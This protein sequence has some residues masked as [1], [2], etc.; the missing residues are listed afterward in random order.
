LPAAD[1]ALCLACSN[2]PLPT[3]WIA[4]W[5][6]YSGSLERVLHAFKFERHDFLD[7]ELGALLGELFTQRDD[8]DFDCVVPVP[9]HRRK[10]RARGYNQ[11][12]LL[13]RQLAASAS[14]ESLPRLLR[15]T[16]DNETQSLLPRDQREAN[17]KRVFAAHAQAQGQAVLLVDDI[18][19]TGETLRAAARTLLEA[20]ARRVAAITVARA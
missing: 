15:K 10:L 16:T 20:G 5:G 12:E 9:M 8:G 17:L 4:S 19:T 6:H 11:A 1:G 2:D 13:A 3:D 7:V 18:C 14:L